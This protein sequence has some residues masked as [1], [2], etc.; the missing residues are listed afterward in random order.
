MR[1]IL[2][3]LLFNE[4][5]HKIAIQVVK[6]VVEVVA[7]KEVSILTNIL[8]EE[9]DVLSGFIA[10]RDYLLVVGGMYSLEYTLLMYFLVA[11]L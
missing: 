1:D 8:R 11:I 6:V 7:C 2:N 10:E 5:F 3:S 4:A 9:H